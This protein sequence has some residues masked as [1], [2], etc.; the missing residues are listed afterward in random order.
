[1]TPFSIRRTILI[2]Y[3]VALAIISF[4]AV[5]TYINMQK[6]ERN[7]QQEE[8]TL[9]S[10]RVIESVFDDVQNIETGQ[11]GYVI[12]GDEEFL[13]PYLSG[14]EKLAKDSLS[15]LA[16]G[17]KD[18]ERKKDIR[19]LLDLVAG[20]VAFAKITVDIG[21]THGLNR[22]EE[23]I[24]SAEGKKLMDAIRKKIEKI[25][26]EDREK[27]NQYTSHRK[28]TARQTTIL[29]FILGSLF[30]LFLLTFFLFI[31]R[32]IRNRLHQEL[33]SQVQE[34]T[35]AFRDI[36]DRIS[37]GFIA[38]DKEWR[39]VYIN[40]EASE[41][42]G[43]QPAEL[44]G[45]SMWDLYPDAVGNE[46]YRAY[47]AA[48]EKQQYHFIEAYYQEY[49]KWFENH[50]YPSSGGLSIHFRDI[51][52]KKKTELSLAQS[53]E[54]F[55]AAANA[56]NDVLWEVDLQKGTLWWNDNFYRKF[57][58][59]K[60]VVEQD[61]MSWE[62]FL[63]PDDK[64]RV[65]NSINKTIESTAE[66]TWKE[67]YKFAKSD[68]S[69]LN[70]YD[71]CYIL[72]NAEGKAY[73]MIGSMTD[74]TP[75]FEAREELKQ[76][77]DRYRNLFERASDTIV[78]HDLKGDILEINQAATDYSGFSKGELKNMNVAD[79]LFKED[80]ALQPLPFDEL[81]SGKTTHNR[82]RIQTKDKRVL[83]MDISSKILPDGNVMA[84]IRDVTEKTKAEKALRDS[85]L[86][87]R[88]LADNTPVGIFQTDAEG[89]TTYVNEKWMEYS[90]LT[91]DEVMGEGWTTAVHPE[92]RDMLLRNWYDKVTVHSESI[93]EYRLIN[94]EGITRWVSGRAVPLYDNEGIL[95]GYLGTISDITQEK[96][97]LESL[98]ASE[99]KYRT[100]VEQATD[101]IFIADSD[102]RFIVVNSSGCGMTQ[103]SMEE[104]LGK[105]IYD[106][107]DPEELKQNPFHFSEMNSTKGVIVEG[108]MK[109]KD[110]VLVD[111][112]V[113]AKFLSD[114]R[115]LAFI[116]DITERKKAEAAMKAS[117]ETRRLIMNSALDAIICMDTGGFITVWTKQA[118]KIFGW[119]EEEMI[120]TQLSDS[121]IPE[122]YRKMHQDGL[123]RYL[124][125]GHGPVLNRMIEINGLNKK[126]QEFPVEL[127]IVHVLQGDIQFFCAYIRDITERKKTEDEIV[128][129]RKQF[130]NLV[131]NISGVYWVNNLDQQQ[132]LYVSPSYETV[133]GRACRDLY[134]NPAD[135]INAIHPEDRNELYKAYENIADTLKTRISYRI[136][137]PDREI[138]WITARTN[139]IIDNNGQKIEYGYA[140]DVTE[141]RKAEEN[142][143]K[144]NERFR[145]IAR[146]TNEAIWEMDLQT[147]QAWGNDAHQYLYGLTI[148]DAV[149]SHEDWIKRIHP[150]DREETLRS[151]R[152]TF[153]SKESTWIAEYRFYTEKEELINIYDRT[154]IVRNEAGEPIRMMGSMM[155]ITERK[156]AEEEIVKARDMADKLIDAL[157]GVF[158][159]YDEKGKFIRWNRQLEIVTGYSAKEISGM[160]PVDLFPAEEK[161]YINKRIEGV[162]ETGSNDAEANFLTKSGEEIPY[163][164]KAVLMNYEGKP[165]LLGSGIDITERKKAEEQVRASEQKY[166]LLFESNPQPMWMFDL[167]AYNIIDV[168]DAA[169]KQYG[170]SRKEF[171]SLR[172][173]DLRPAEDVEQFMKYLNTNFREG[174]HYAGA[175]RHKK[176]NGDIIYVDILSHDII[177]EEKPVRLIL[178]NNITDKYI[179]EEKLKESYEAIRELTGHIQNIREEERSHIAREIHDELGQQL[180]VLKMDVS[181]LN[182]KMGHSNEIVTNK[183]KSLAE[184]IDGTVKTV[185]R[186][187]SELRP[188]LLDDLGLVAAMDWHLKE[189]GRR[190]GIETV[191]NEP[192]HDLPV[193][194]KFKTGLY[195]IFQESL[196]NVAR[197]SGATL[198]KVV[199]EEKENYLM[200]SI[201]DNGKGFDMQE[202]K[203]R[204]TLGILGMKE[205]SMMMGGIYEISSLPGKGTIIT[206]SVPVKTTL[207]EQA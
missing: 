167:P 122:Q 116:R 39:Y 113:N 49:N 155:N 66:T 4:F 37:D 109:R 10:L 168:N 197:H 128:K 133:W 132:T 185:R 127:S 59:E 183:L 143:I 200:L 1:M 130:Q 65:I 123:K 78:I 22:A 117:E 34:K 73:K 38:L 99:E 115:F 28:E 87:F 46:F 175:W 144:A 184:M 106:L 189:F 19:Q 101:G 142:I 69:Y 186:I 104:I 54:R 30:F 105:T 141:Q 5:Y 80:L 188:S 29:F 165:C 6:G 126:G 57:G 121:I 63:H 154:Y 100:L 149:P 205:R 20:K 170:Y 178:A 21:E 118:E 206:V 111:I 138:R 55:N 43:R 182:K 36:L 112:E 195:R 89:Q 110:G 146:T 201:E 97:A 44:L 164:F 166:K 17:I 88:T 70:I 139:V 150:D 108:K 79:L 62:N 204:R 53:I 171:L 174:V 131:E 137:R 68:G 203:D 169:A 202:T 151:Y 134:R 3:I 74:V 140:E 75:L 9:R 129:S 192:E 96:L 181:W 81:N 163:Y 90:G 31:R 32:D 77:E 23:R 158:Y 27:L 153:S 152:D 157:P 2:G 41:L 47:H 8:E 119:T 52:D 26:S 71:R 125:T 85:E 15:I 48:M 33:T 56:T 194:E 107:V 13:E 102:G 82:R 25:E 162:F 51:T 92:D 145:L 24:Q 191:F 156:K 193:P 103:Y 76:S 196:T 94:K 50:I 187:S 58:Y 11:R 161:E 147:G 135:F 86:R 72:R 42:I 136:V 176:K 180:T 91:F 84:V 67:E 179:A 199:L 124:D 18:E 172:A 207:K 177:Y 95:T 61:N 120:G 45:R 190:S 14:L 12:S 160:H 35:I 40:N 98:K 173:S 60:E 159:F 64:E 148:K 198:V 7:A 114:N 83:T 93:S 16:L